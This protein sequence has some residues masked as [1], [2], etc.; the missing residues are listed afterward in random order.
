RVRVSRAQAGGVK[1]RVVQVGGRG[2]G[3]VPPRRGVG[4]ELGQPVRIHVGAADGQLAAARGGRVG[5]PAADRGERVRGH[6]PG[7]QAHRGQA[8]VV[9]QGG[10]RRRQR[11]TGGQA[12]RG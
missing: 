10:Q 9:G 8:A 2:H 12:D 3:P 4:L 11:R 5:R 6:V 7:Q 1:V